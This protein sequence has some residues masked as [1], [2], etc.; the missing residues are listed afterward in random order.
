MEIVKK[1]REF[2]EFVVEPITHSEEY[3]PRGGVSDARDAAWYALRNVPRL[4][5]YFPTMEASA[6]LEEFC[7]AAE[8]IANTLESESR[9]TGPDKHS[10]TLNA[11]GHLCIL[12]DNAGISTKLGSEK[13]IRETNAP[14]WFALSRIFLRLASERIMATGEEDAKKAQNDPRRFCGLSAITF[15]RQLQKA[16]LVSH[17]ISARQSSSRT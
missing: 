1:C 13:Y 9:K 6:I 12:L 4:G 8:H 14:P 5:D 10:L 16:R 15:H 7:E 3:S 17:S 2:I 11:L